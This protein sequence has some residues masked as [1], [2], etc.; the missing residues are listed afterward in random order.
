[1]AVVLSAVSCGGGGD[2]T[3]PKKPPAQTIAFLRAVV[4]GQPANQAA[5]LDALE[6][7]G[8]VEGDN[9]TLVAKDANEVHSDPADVEAT[10]RRWQADGVD[11]I[12]ALST[13]GAQIAAKAAPDVNVLF[14]VNDPKAGGLVEDER[15]P[16]GR[17]TG[18][19]FRVPADRTLDIARQALPKV[20]TFGI[21]YPPADPA[22]LA[23]RGAAVDAAADLDVAIVE[24]TFADASNAAAAVTGVRAKGAGAVW[25]LNSPTTVRFIAPI[26]EAATARRLPLVTN[27]AVDAALITLQ[28][29]V[30]T[31]YRQVARQAVLLFSGTPVREIPV[32]NPA[33][34]E[35]IVSQPV[36]AALGI[37]LPES[38]VKRADRVIR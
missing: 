30:P 16:S 22:A 35:L 21:V 23:V 6:D 7:A 11:V 25:A 4:S 24:G 1:M 27:T 9:L 29:D 14:L 33:K 3:A 5:F 34:F 28:P 26:A 17:S 18:V 37:T 15:R 38:V 2:E 12:V 19:T 13:T 36:A 8:Y 20:S 32:E 31:L 10:V